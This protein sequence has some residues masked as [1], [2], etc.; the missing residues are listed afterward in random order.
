MAT[1][2]DISAVRKHFPALDQKQVFF[3]V[4]TVFPA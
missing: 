3:D 4:G 2:I 1:T